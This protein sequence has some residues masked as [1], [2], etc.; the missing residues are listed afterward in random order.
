MEALM[1]WDVEKAIAAAMVE[2]V[3]EGGH[4]EL[5]VVAI[6]RRAGVSRWRF[7]E[8]YADLEDCYL[9]TFEVHSGRFEAEVTGAFEADEKAAW[10]DRLRAA[11]YA[12]ATFIDREPALARFATVVRADGGDEALRLR[13][14]RTQ[15]LVDLIDAGRSELSDPDSLG[16]GY[17]EVLFG[18]VHQML[19]R[20]LRHDERRSA[21]SFVPELM[22]LAV[23]PY[24]G[25]AAAQEEL[26]APAPAL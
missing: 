8:H 5:S 1:R 11:A 6:C 23:L 26:A 9:R 10:R 13:E 19:L 18:G 15:R 24:L 2:L 21:V 14:A 25:R 20:G 17:A 12:A 16:R 7:A 3:A 22:Y 4:R